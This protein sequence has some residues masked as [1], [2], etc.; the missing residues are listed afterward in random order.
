MKNANIVVIDD[1]IENVKLLAAILETQGHRVSA[2]TKPL[3]IFSSA[4]LSIPDMFMIDINMPELDGFSLCQQLR[5]E[6]LLK[7]I[8]IIFVSG[9]D[10]STEKVKAFSLGAV[11]YIPKPFAMNELIARVSSHLKTYRLES[12]LK[13]QNLRLEET[14]KELQSTKTILLESERINAVSL[15]IKQLAH[16]LNTPLSI[17][18]IANDSNKEN[19]QKLDE[20]INQNILSKKMISHYIQT[21]HDSQLLTESNL[22]KLIATIEKITSLIDESN[23]EKDI[24]TV[25]DKFLKH[26]KQQYTDITIDYSCVKRRK[27]SVNEKLFLEILKIMFEELGINNKVV[28]ETPH[29]FINIIEENEHC[30]FRMGNITLPNSSLPLKEQTQGFDKDGI[31]QLGY[32]IVKMICVSY[33]YELLTSRAGDFTIKIPNSQVSLA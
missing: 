12:Q 1:D 24:D 11:D 31:K 29:Y 3:E 33:D 10:D 23:T 28:A 8:P 25:V 7:D 13:E 9:S 30:I 14:I 6:P 5:S 20:Q 21:T 18:R 19:L 2:S 27:I 15:F 17:A 26:T 16:E 32:K 4:K 22:L